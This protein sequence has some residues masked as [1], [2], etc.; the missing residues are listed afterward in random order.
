MPLVPEHQIELPIPRVAGSG[1]S[2]RAKF[3]LVPPLESPG[4]SS[5]RPRRQPSRATRFVQLAIGFPQ[6][7]QNLR[8]RST[9]SVR[10]LHGFVLLP[11]G[12]SDYYNNSCQYM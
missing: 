12:I 11:S 1:D 4:A 6:A 2:R 10:L 3:H 8:I 9:M 7:C 5:A